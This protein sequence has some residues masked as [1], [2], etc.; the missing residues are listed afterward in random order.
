MG[1]W[2]CVYERRA[3]VA[4]VL[5]EEWGEHSPLGHETQL[6]DMSMA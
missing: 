2:I 3:M 1:F 6:G 4:R 5:D